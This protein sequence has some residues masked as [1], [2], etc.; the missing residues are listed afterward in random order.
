MNPVIPVYLF[1]I[2]FCLVI[3]L[4][5]ITGDRRNAKTK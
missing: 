1:G 2:V 4:I 5:T 3:I